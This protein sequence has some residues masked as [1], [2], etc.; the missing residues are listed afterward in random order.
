MA[1]QAEQCPVCADKFFD[2]TILASHGDEYGYKCATCG[3]FRIT[4]LAAAGLAAAA[5]H[6]KL[7]AWIRDHEE[8]ELEPPFLDQ[9]SLENLLPNIPNPSPVK[10]Q[11]NLLRAI[12]RRSDHP[13]EE[14]KLAAQDYPLCWAKKVKELD[15]HLKELVRNGYLER[16]SRAFIYWVT[17]EGWGYLEESEET[18][19]NPNRGFVA[20]SFNLD[21]KSVYESAIKPGIIAAGYKAHRVD[22]T[23]HQDKIDNKIIADLKESAFVVADMTE[24]KH[25]VYFEAGFALG[26]GRPVFWSVRKD[27]LENAHFDTR[28]YPHIVWEKHEELRDGLTNAILATMGRGP[29]RVEEA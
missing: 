15:F 17:T 25:G 7:S 6:P 29:H 22:E 2:R 10:K 12:A 20:M 13:G 24:H 8:R 18:P 4:G 9:E 28:Q 16:L 21:L 3:E 19:I 11:L 23:H 1:N 5:P 14:V 27:D 26:L